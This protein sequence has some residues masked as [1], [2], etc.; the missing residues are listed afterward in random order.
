MPIRKD[1]TYERRETKAPYI[2]TSAAGEGGVGMGS[3][4]CRIS[5]GAFFAVF[6]AGA[7]L[8][9]ARMAEWSRAALAPMWLLVGV[10]AGA[11][12]YGRRH[13]GRGR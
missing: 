7:A 3:V 4:V 2:L 10:Q 5:Q 12:A 1:L 8:W 11:L 9:A 13:E 6:A